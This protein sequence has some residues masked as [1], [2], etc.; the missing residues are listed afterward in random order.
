M[1]GSPAASEASTGSQMR[2][3]GVFGGVGAAPGAGTKALKS[4]DFG[5]YDHQ[6]HTPGRM[7]MSR[8]MSRTLTTS[9]S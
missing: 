6:W 2:P 3:G 8:L 4:L 9:R 1:A 7:T 5:S